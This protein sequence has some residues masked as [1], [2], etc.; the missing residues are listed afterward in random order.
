[1][2][3]VQKIIEKKKPI[4]ALTILTSPIIKGI[5]I[6]AR[7]TCPMSIKISES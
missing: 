2:L 6:E 1:M 4:I 3:A 5:K 7:Q